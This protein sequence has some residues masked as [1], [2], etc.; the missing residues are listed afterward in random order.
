MPRMRCSFFAVC[1]GLSFIALFATLLVSALVPAASQG[2]GAGEISTQVNDFTPNT[3][4]FAL[5]VLFMTPL[6]AARAQY[7]FRGYLPQLFGGHSPTVQALHVPVVPFAVD[8]GTHDP[9]VFVAP[10]A[11]GLR[12]GVLVGRVLGRCRRRGWNESSGVTSPVT[13]VATAGRSWRSS[14]RVCSSR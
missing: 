13:L 3:M 9:L 5:V 11:L 2:D 7:H 1:L 4:Q 8:H 12:F 14:P 6:Q 10:S